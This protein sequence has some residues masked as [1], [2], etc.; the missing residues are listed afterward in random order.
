MD[1]SVDNSLDESTESDEVSIWDEALEFSVEAHT[2]DCANEHVW[3][4]ILFA[5]T[6][7]VLMS[8][9]D[10]IDCGSGFHESKQ[11]GAYSLRQELDGKPVKGTEK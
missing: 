11:S 10:L 4:E 3:T 5:S 6:L 7:R 8:L 9:G 2:G 1:V